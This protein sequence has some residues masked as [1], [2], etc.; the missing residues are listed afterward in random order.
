MSARNFADP[1]L[2][3]TLREEG[4]LSN[5]PLDPGRLTF[6]GITLEAWRTHT[7]N[8]RATAAELEALG[9]AQVAAFYGSLW[10]SV[11]G[12]DLADG[13]DGMLFDHFVNSG[14]NAGKVLQRV[15]GLTGAAVD[16]W[17]GAETLA[18]L[19]RVDAGHLALRMLPGGIA[20]FQAAAGLHAD[21]KIGPLTMGAMKAHPVATLVC[22]LH[23]AQDSY[24]RALPGYAHDGRGWEA[25][26][27]RRGALAMSLALPAA[28][29]LQAP[30]S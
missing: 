21:G 3:F 25:R 22:A 5:D 24:Y 23:D 1:L 20:L 11:R 16:G 15:A 14:A 2:P 13:L 8:P 26:L 17:I 6:R 10:N 19:G 27:G 12:D 30:I 18:A 4:G 9:D 28:S 29:R 7:R